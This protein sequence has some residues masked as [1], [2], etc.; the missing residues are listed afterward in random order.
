MATLGVHSWRKISG[1]RRLEGQVTHIDAL[2]ESAGFLRPDGALL[3]LSWQNF[4]S[5]GTVKRS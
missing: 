1:F 2:Q 4:F 3:V 5:L